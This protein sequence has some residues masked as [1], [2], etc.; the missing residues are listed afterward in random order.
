M[1]RE[2][3]KDMVKFPF[4]AG[5]SML[6]SEALTY[7]KECNIRHLPVL[8]NGRLIGIVSERDLV[9]EASKSQTL[10]ETMIPRPYV[11][12]EKENLANVVSVMAEMKYGCAMVLNDLGYLVGIF[13]TVD[14][15]KLLEKFLSPDSQFYNSYENVISLKEA[16]D[17][18]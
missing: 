7:M 18:I 2:V 1:Y 11:V 13:T 16:A 15:L 9:T 12:N 5:P 10:D 14:A 17:W 8:K 3:N 4:V 6:G